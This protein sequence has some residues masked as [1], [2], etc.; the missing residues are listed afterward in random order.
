MR[1]RSQDAVRR[2]AARHRER[3]RDALLSAERSHDAAM[4][5]VWEEIAQDHAR[6]AIAYESSRGG[7]VH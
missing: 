3:E 6:I 7:T 1:D 2:L 4:R 5:E